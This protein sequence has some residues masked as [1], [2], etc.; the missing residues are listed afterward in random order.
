[1]HIYICVHVCVCVYVCNSCNMGK[2]G[3]PHIYSQ[4]QKAEV[5]YVTGFAKRGL[6]HANINI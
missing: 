3:L 5:V 2:S 4:S 1:M 6:I